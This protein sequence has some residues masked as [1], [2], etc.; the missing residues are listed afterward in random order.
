M[1]SQ[2]GDSQPAAPPGAPSRP[3]WVAGALAVVAAG[4]L[5][6][7]IATLVHP[8]GARRTSARPATSPPGA[9]VGGHGPGPGRH[10]R[11]HRV[12]RGH[13]RR[14]LRPHQRP[15]HRPGRERRT[16][17]RS[18]FDDGR[19]RCR[20]GSS[21]RD[22]ATDLAVLKVDADRA[23]TPIIAIGSSADAAGR[24]AGGRAR[25]S[26]RAVQHGDHRHGQRAGP[27]VPVPS[28]TSA[29]RCS[30]PRSRPTPRST[31]ATAAARWSTA[32]AG[33]SACRHRR[34][35]VPDAPAGRRRQH[36]HRLRH[37]GRLGAAHRRPAHQHRLGPARVRRP[38][39]GADP[40]RGQR[41]RRAVR[42]RRDA[43]RPGA[44][45]GLRAGD[46]I[47][48]LDGQPVGDAEQLDV[49]SVTRS[50]G[51][52]VPVTTAG[53]G[54]APRRPSRSAPPTATN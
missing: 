19:P 33:W 16:G 29:P 30:P 54:P 41:A 6:A 12:G 47:T 5:G 7:L 42:H 53:T 2:P 34:R 4:L 52:R 46:V 36:R 1:H 48:A 27:D 49:L 24:S 10:R 50:P 18:S 44:A 9:A 8:S 28:T 37:P 3:W 40:A 15:R 35:T 25:R 45:A 21:G 22:P 11:R 39:G 32:P 20:P 26:A 38:R 31:P 13:P 14:R 23:P 51:D 17:S 43:R